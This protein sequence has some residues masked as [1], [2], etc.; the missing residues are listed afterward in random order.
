MSRNAEIVPPPAGVIAGVALVAGTPPIR[1]GSI[2][3]D[4]RAIDAAYQ[5]FKYLRKARTPTTSRRSQGP[6]SKLFG[7]A[8]VTSTARS[9]PTGPQDRSLDSRSPRCS[10]WHGSSRNR[11]RVDR[12]ADRRRCHRRALQLNRR[13]RRRAGRSRA[14]APEMNPLVNPARSRRRAWSRARSADEVWKKII[15]F[16]NDCR[17]TRA[18]GAAGRYKS[19]SDTTSATRRSARSCSPMATS[20]RTGSRR[21]NLVHAAVLDRRERK[22]LATMAATLAAWRHKSGHRQE[23]AHATKVPGVLAAMATAGLYDD[24]GKWLYHTGLPEERRRRR[25]SPSRP[26]GFG[27]VSAIICGYAATASAPACNRRDLE[28]VG[29]A[30][31]RRQEGR[32]SVSGCPNDGQRFHAWACSPALSSWERRHRRRPGRRTPLARATLVRLKRPSRPG[33]RRQS[34]AP[35]YHLTAPAAPSGRPRRR[36]RRSLWARQPGGG[37][38]GSHTPLRWWDKHGERR[39]GFGRLHRSTIGYQ[40]AATTDS[41]CANRPELLR[42]RSHGRFGRLTWEYFGETTNL[43]ERFHQHHARRH[44]ARRDAPSRRVGPFAIRTTRKGQL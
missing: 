4:N 33:G 31:L 44:R 1:A 38:Y 24:S 14:G 21:S 28:C 43:P 3:H 42:V 19:E 2:Q 26:A 25:S 39:G 10:R 8:L 16:H 18:D 36:Q 12:E 37:R 29:G 30:I 20:S 23:G 17:R 9:T 35:P 7:I 13:R 6:K 34:C 40:K 15:G 11:D 27:K 22:D 41:G 32:T 5:K